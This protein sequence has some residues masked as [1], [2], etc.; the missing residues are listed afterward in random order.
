M[1]GYIKQ[2][3]KANPGKETTL[4]NTF[5][6]SYGDAAVAKMLEAAKR[7]PGTEKFAKEL[8]TAQFQQWLVEG[9]KPAQIWKTLKME[10]ST[11]MTNPDAEVWR[12]YLAFYKANK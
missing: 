3:N 10:K 12:G 11:W 6:V 1:T 8:Q 7:K 9:A 5:A 2:F 4:V